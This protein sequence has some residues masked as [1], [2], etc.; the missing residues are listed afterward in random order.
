MSTH[1]PSKR[2]EAEV[3][4]LLPCAVCALRDCWLREGTR[5]TC[6]ALIGRVLTSGDQRGMM[7]SARLHVW[8]QQQVSSRCS[9]TRRASRRSVE[10][11]ASCRGAY[12]YE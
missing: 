7:A 6:R 4:R 2:E 11:I 9:S 3:R 1:T 8:Y 10:R 12:K 5:D